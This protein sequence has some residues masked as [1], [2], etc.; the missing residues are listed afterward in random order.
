MRIYTSN[1]FGVDRSQKAHS[2]KSWGNQAFKNNRL[3]WGESSWAGR[4]AGRSP[5]RSRCQ[6]KQ[7]QNDQLIWVALVSQFVTSSGL[8]TVLYL[9]LIA[10]LLN[11]YPNLI[12]KFPCSWPFDRGGSWQA[13]KTASL[14]TTWVNIIHV[15]F[16]IHVGIYWAII[17]KYWQII[18]D[19]C[20]GLL[21]FKTFEST[22]LAGAWWGPRAWRLVSTQSFGER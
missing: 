7:R 12:A 14:S 4:M 5:Q 20:I 6:V 13:G 8:L 16:S 9:A 21:Q 10:H 11:C 3:G 19:L 18:V 22:K 1:G 2:Y 15:E 17:W